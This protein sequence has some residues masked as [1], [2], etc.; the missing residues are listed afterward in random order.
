MSWSFSHPPIICVQWQSL[1]GGHT[2]HFTSADHWHS[3]LCICFF[4]KHS[5]ISVEHSRLNFFSLCH[6]LQSLSHDALCILFFQKYSLLTCNQ[7]NWSDYRCG[8]HCKVSRGH[9]RSPWYQRKWTGSEEVSLLDYDQY[10]P[11]LIIS[12]WVPLGFVCGFIHLANKFLVALW[13]WSWMKPH[14]LG[15][16]CSVD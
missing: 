13:L 7:L 6:I 5:C 11:A 1:L 8:G 4:V 12:D 2:K 9:T 14:T 15:F 3:C 16:T 10:F